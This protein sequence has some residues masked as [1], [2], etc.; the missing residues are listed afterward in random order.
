MVEEDLAGTL[1]HGPLHRQVVWVKLE[2]ELADGLGCG[3]D[4]I[5][6]VLADNR[7]VDVEAGLAGRLHE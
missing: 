1:R 3:A 6:V 5:I 7:H 4:L 2:H